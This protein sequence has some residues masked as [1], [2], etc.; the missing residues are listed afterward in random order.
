MIKKNELFKLLNR[1]SK[2]FDLR[3]FSLKLRENN[4]NTKIVF[5]I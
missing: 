4:N 1:E 5:V 3:Y 2:E